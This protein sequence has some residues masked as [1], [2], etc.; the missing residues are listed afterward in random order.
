MDRSPLATTL[1]PL[2]ALLY[3]DRHHEVRTALLDLAEEWGDR[4]AGRHACGPDQATAYLTTHGDA[5]RCP[6][7]PPLRTLGAMLRDHV[8]D[9]VTDVHLL[10]MLP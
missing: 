6:G 2:V 9:A 1:D 10:P 8:W 3:P 7:E 4:L 5:I